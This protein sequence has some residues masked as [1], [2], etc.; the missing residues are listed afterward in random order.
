MKVNL[1]GKTGHSGVGIYTQELREALSKKDIEIDFQKTYSVLNPD[2]LNQVLLSRFLLDKRSDI[3]HITTQDLM[4]A[5]YLSTNQK[6]VVTVHDIF[7][8]LDYSGKVYSWMA[9][10]YVRNIEKKADRVIAISEFTKEQLIEN[11]SLDSSDIDVVYQGVDLETFRPQK[12]KESKDYFLHV[13]SEIDRKN[14][15]GLIEIFE[16]IKKREQDTKLIRVGNISEKTKKIIKN[17]DLVLGKDIVYKTDITEEKLVELY[18]GARKLLFPSHAEGFGRPI[19]E[20]LAC[21]TP[22]VAYNKKPMSEI[23]PEEMMVEYRD[24]TKFVE[25]ALSTED[26]NPRDYAEDF[27]WDRTAEEVIKTYERA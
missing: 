16:E 26:N 23:L 4:S 17:S 11:T 14:I 12:E 20:S 25:K 8:Y 9:K 18:S 19:I 2:F 3:N 27:T 13:G 7:P 24:Q 22:V 10:R 5:Y 15:E 1:V 6:I 21:G